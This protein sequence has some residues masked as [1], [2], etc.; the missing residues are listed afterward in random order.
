M[1]PEYRKELIA[2]RSYI[3]QLIREAEDVLVGPIDD[4]IMLRI[5]N[6]LKE[7]REVLAEVKAKLDRLAL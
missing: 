4:E 6:T 1:H 7:F 2:L 5:S 3:E